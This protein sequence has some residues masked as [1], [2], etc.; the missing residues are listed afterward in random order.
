MINT[1]KNKKVKNKILNNK[2]I[3][4][5]IENIDKIYLNKENK[6]LNYFAIKIQKNYRGYIFRLKRLPLILYVFQNYIKSKSIKLTDKLTDGRINSTFDE[7][8]I[9]DLLELK[10]KNKI[11]RPK[12]RHWFDMLIKD[13]YY[14][15][16]PVNI[17]TSKCDTS[18][19]T[20]NFAICV[21]SYTNEKLDFN[22]T[23]NNGEMSKILIK[24]VKK[25]EYNKK[26]KK[27]YYFIIINKNNTQEIIIN[28]VKG[29]KLLTPNI[30]NLP[31]QVRWDKNKNFEYKK[32]D[33]SIKQFVDC[34]KK[35]KPSWKE[36][37]MLNIRN[38]NI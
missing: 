15:W 4:K 13:Y 12:E 19:N 37:F 28:S 36:I 38:I 6:K 9:I 33:K 5:I 32:I 21:Y 35:P 24:K 29:L 11:K 3:E 20:G 8:K 26:N 31:F 17:K 10:Y 30:N 23:Y 27:D 7:K 14:G 1:K 22:R 2:E 34:L 18:D 16:I 25:K